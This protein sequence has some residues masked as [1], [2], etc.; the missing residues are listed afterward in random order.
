MADRES[1]NFQVNFT[2]EP[3]Q[4]FDDFISTLKVLDVDVNGTDLTCEGS[5]GSRMTINSTIQI[6]IVG[7]TTTTKLIITLDGVLT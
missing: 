1:D 3:G 7:K 4:D 5:V 6:C 2:S